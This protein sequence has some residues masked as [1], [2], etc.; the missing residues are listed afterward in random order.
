MSNEEN[1][2]YRIDGKNISKIIE[3]VYKIVEQKRQNN[4][5]E[6]INKISNVCIDPTLGNISYELLPSNEIKISFSLSETNFLILNSRF[7]TLAKAS[8][9]VGIIILFI[10]QP[11]LIS[12]RQN[13]LQKFYALIII[14]TH[15]FIFLRFLFNVLNSN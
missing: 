9:A 14:Y 2:Y 11:P 1:F 10:G 4:Q 12:T 6:Q 7:I 3:Q 5:D 13:I 8:S 15:N